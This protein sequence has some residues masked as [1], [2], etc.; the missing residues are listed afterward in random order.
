M[1]Q[2]ERNERAQISQL[3]TS[4]SERGFGA[5][6]SVTNTNLSELCTVV[7]SRLLCLCNCIGTPFAWSATANSASPKCVVLNALQ[8]SK[9]I[10]SICHDR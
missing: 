10:T 9:A 3:V 6:L 2:E 7:L 1:C 4:I 5:V 8:S